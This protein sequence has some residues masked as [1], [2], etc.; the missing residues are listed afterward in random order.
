MDQAVWCQRRGE[1]AKS[2]LFCVKKSKQYIKCD[3][4]WKRAVSMSTFGVASCLASKKITDGSF[5]G[6]R[7]VN[8]KQKKCLSERGNLE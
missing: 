6:V 1:G 3:V 5:F 2:V 4:W 8:I 7:S